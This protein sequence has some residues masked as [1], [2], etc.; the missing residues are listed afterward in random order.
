[1]SKENLYVTGSKG[2]I[3]SE[4]VKGFEGKVMLITPEIDELDITSLASIERYFKDQKLSAVI[5]FAAFT[6]VAAAQAETD[7]NGPFW[8]ANVVG[9][10]NLAKFAF[11]RG[12]PMIHI[13]TDFVFAGTK[14][15]PGP[16][17]EFQNSVFYKDKFG[18]YATTKI[19]A[20]RFLRE[21]AFRQKGRLTIVRISY[22]FGNA[23]IEK[24]F[25]VKMIKRIKVGGALFDD[26]QITPTY[27]SDLTRSLGIIYQNKLQGIYHVACKPPTTPYEIGVYLSQKLGLGEV[28]SS[29]VETYFED[30]QKNPELLAPIPK[31][32]GLDTSLSEEELG[33]FHTWQKALDE[34]LPQLKGT[35]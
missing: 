9:A 5:N 21:E 28:K 10:L 15:Y 24:D 17:K 7:I 33:T 22:P 4:V 16:Y 26:Q 31:I 35:L 19:F 34:Y 18:W 12:I 32:G 20:E 6:N 27:I 2:M 25:V 3:A 14:D 23:L 11:A 1:M 29:S 30:A 13:S 8:Q